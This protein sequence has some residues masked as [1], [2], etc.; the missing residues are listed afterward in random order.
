[1]VDVLLGINLIFSRNYFHQH[2]PEKDPGLL[3][4]SKIDGRSRPE[5][6][7]KKGVFRNFAKFTGKRLRQSLFFK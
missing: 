1:M 2:L 3:Q 7:C 5:V 6:F 4:T